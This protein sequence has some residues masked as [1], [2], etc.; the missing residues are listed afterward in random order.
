MQTLQVAPI[1]GMNTFK[2]YT[3]FLIQR[4]FRKYLDQSDEVHIIFD[5]PNV[6]GFNLTHNVS[7]KNEF[8]SKQVPVLVDPKFLDTTPI[9]VKASNW[10]S[11]LAKKENQQKLVEYVGEKLLDL[12]ET[13]SK[14]MSVILGGCT[15][16]DKTYRIEN[17]KIMAEESLL[18]FH[19]EASTRLLA[20][21]AWSHRSRLQ[22]VASDGEILAILLLNWTL[23]SSKTILLEQSDSFN[24]LHVNELVEAM[25]EDRD[26]VLMV[27][28]QRGNVTMTTFF[29]MLHPL[30]GSDILASPRTFG[31]NHI[32]RTCI[33]FAS[34]LF[35]GKSSIHLLAD[36]ESMNQDAY[37]RFTLA[38]FKKRYANK[39]KLKAEE[40]F[41]PEAYLTEVLE[42]VRK[43]HGSTHW[44]VTAFCRHM[45]V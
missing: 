5:R 24:L 28:R 43:V 9:P 4:K 32:L 41:S 45:S 16:D 30:I 17:G 37:A 11:F 3:D 44:R 42:D 13:L 38:L 31:P 18:C 23:F 22:F 14:D 15:Q 8:R 20:H 1:Y 25:Y 39:I 2:H 29:G 35:E 36:K 27:L 7:E 19:D 21:A 12:A 34:Y 10:S 40:I 6:C 26:Q 33:D